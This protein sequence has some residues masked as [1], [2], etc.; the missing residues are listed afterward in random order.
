MGVG[1][2]MLSWSVAIGY[3]AVGGLVV[4]A[5]FTWRRL[6]AWQQACHVAAADRKPRPTIGRFVDPAPDV[7]VALSRAA[8]GAAAGWLLHAEVTGVYAAVTVG[9]S[10]PGLLAS[11]GKATT[12]LEAVR[13]EPKA[14]TAQ[15]SAPDVARLPD[16]QPEAVE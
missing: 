14:D 13:A 8:L 3:G 9:A 6:Y 1:G 12:G 11:L 5:A 16:P 7:A 4:E 10:A 2:G 15:P